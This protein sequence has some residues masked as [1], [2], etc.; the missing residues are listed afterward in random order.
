MKSESISSDVEVEDLSSLTKDQ[1]VKL[2]MDMRSKI[3]EEN[4]SYKRKLQTF[5]ESQ[6][7]QAQLVQKLQQKVRTWAL[8]L[9]RIDGDGN[10]AAVYTGLEE[11]ETISI[12]ILSFEDLLWPL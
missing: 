4:Q 5:Q 8:G 6:T 3:E 11:K 12:R 7:R 2:N 10:G 9:S 1:L